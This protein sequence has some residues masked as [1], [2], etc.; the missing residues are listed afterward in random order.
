MKTFDLM[1]KILIDLGDMSSLTSLADDYLT[2]ADLNGK[3]RADILRKMYSVI[4]LI[5]NGLKQ[6]EQLIC[7]E[8]YKEKL[9]RIEQ[10]G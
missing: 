1:D 10:H 9:G 8:F 3:D 4:T 7:R 6:T 2:M 5:A